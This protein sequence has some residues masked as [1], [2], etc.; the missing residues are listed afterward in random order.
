MLALSASAAWPACGIAQTASTTLPRAQVAAQRVTPA[1]RRDL[2]ALGLRFGD[3][4]FIRIFKHEHQLEIWVQ[5]NGRYALFRQY[6][7]CTWSGALGPK[8]RQGDGQSPEGFYSVGRGQLNP[9]SSYHLA[10]NLGYPNAYDRAH[11]R[12]GNYLM[13]HGRC[14]SI[15][16]YAM[17]DANIEQIYTLLDAAL[18]GGQRRVDVHVFP[19][20]FDRPPLARWQQHAWGGFWGN[21]QQGYQAFERSRLPPAIDVDGLRYRITARAATESAAAPVH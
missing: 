2:V 9:Q 12:S 21:L 20:R 1:L 15:G 6:P 11:G 18:R 7:I 8:Q 17:G 16:C 19:F 3:P 13:V 4:I 5:K 14:V 10:F